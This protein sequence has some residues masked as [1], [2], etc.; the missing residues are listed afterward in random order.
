MLRYGNIAQIVE[1]LPS[2]LK[3][4]GSIASTNTDKKSKVISLPVH[5]T[6]RCTRLFHQD[7]I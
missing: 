7:P 2:K 6:H 5:L 1:P 3:V 4:L